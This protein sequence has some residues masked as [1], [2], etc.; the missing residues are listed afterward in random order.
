MESLISFKKFFEKG[1]VLIIMRGGNK[2]A[3]QKN[4]VAKG[5]HG[6]LNVLLFFLLRV[7]K[8]LQ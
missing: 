8:M 2:T 1:H 3:S 6:G 7:E 4:I 5:L